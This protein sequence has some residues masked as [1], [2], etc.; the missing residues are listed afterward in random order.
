MG[1]IWRKRDG[2]VANKRTVYDEVFVYVF[3]LRL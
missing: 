2:E 1:E 3:L